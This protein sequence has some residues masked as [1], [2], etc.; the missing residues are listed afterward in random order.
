MIPSISVDSVERLEETR[1][2]L[3]WFWELVCLLH[4]FIYCLNI[5]MLL[6]RHAK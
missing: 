1:L 3:I 6:K 4:D 5:N 2:V